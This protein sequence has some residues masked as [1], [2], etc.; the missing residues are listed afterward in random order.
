M[1]NVGAVM[2]AAEL[3]HL[4]AAAFKPTVIRG[5]EFIFLTPYTVFPTSFKANQTNLWPMSK[6]VVRLSRNRLLPLPRHWVR[7]RTAPTPA[8]RVIDKLR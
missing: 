8:N 5:G 3:L 7:H 1:L 6:S 4:S 2:T